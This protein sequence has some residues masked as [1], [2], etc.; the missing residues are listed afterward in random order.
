MNTNA[1]FFLSWPP[2]VCQSGGERKTRL[3][4]HFL[5]FLWVSLSGFGSSFLPKEESVTAAPEVEVSEDYQ[6]SSQV[7]LSFPKPTLFFMFFHLI[8]V[9]SLHIE[10]YEWILLNKVRFWL[11]FRLLFLQVFHEC[12]LNP[13]QNKGTCEE[14]G[15][16]YVCTCAPG[17][18]GKTSINPSVI[19]MHL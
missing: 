18:T 1:G 14:V 8:I 3:R 2:F 7:S 15:A 4:W 12:F 13:C 9:Y 11:W 17:F 5:Y 16:G 6:A 10:I 19:Y